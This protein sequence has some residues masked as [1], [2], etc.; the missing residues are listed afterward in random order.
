MI[1]KREIACQE[2]MRAYVDRARAVNPH[3]NALV[4]TNYDRA[5]DAAAAAGRSLERGEDV[6]PLHGP[7]VS[8]KDALDTSDFRTTWQYLNCPTLKHAE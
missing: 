4:E 3:I 1:R 6:R 2:L 7:P 8:I 5:M